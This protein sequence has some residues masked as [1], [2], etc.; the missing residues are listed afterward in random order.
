MA[1]S[2]KT[3]DTEIITLRQVVAYNSN[4][5]FIPAGRVL[6]SLGNG[7]TAWQNISSLGS[8]LAFNTVIANGTTINA[9]QLTNTL[10]LS[11]LEGMGMTT[12]VPTKTVSLF[13][14]GFSQLD[15]SGNNSIKS[16]SNSLLT[17]TI[18]FAGLEGVTL[19]SDPQTNTVYFRTANP[20]VSTGIYGYHAVNVFSN[21]NTCNNSAFDDPNK[22][23]LNSTSP[24]THLNVFGLNDIQLYANITSNAF[25]IGISSFTSQTY[26]GM[27][28]TISQNASTIS[29]LIIESSSTLSQL[30]TPIY[31]T[32][33]NLS[34]SVA[35]RIDYD[36]NY[37]LTNYVSKNVYAANSTSISGVLSN[38]D[39]P[40]VSSFTVSERSQTG[41]LDTDILYLSSTQL[42]L[43]SMC[44]IIY[45][46]SNPL[47]LSCS[48]SLLFNTNTGG[49][50]NQ[51]FF[52][53]TLLYAGETPLLNTA[54]TRPWMATNTSGSNLYTDTFSLTMSR[55]NAI[56]NMTSS[57][58]LMHQISPFTVGGTGG[59]T[60]QDVSSFATTL[61]LSLP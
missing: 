23:V 5:S 3:Y 45:N 60:T 1:S 29:S 56:D 32:I 46:S 55:A 10:T 8:T 57:I 33:S 34:V 59:I 11:T 42:T 26:L 9:D 52:V 6:T 25:F 47:R 14:K 41:V 61:F 16:Y 15:I 17:P 35:T 28:T 22:A 7:Q 49:T 51:I 12:D 39:A 58:V 27:S 54:F 37:F 40:F 50:Q 4:N 20:I 30:S 2:R 38:L 43:Q 53:S 31:N 18:K 24:S 13:S 48:P 19:S 21:V 44:N 36:A